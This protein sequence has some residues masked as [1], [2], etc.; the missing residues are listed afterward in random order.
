M[1]EKTIAKRY[2][3]G[4]IDAAAPKGEAEKV[5]VE[6]A[7]FA[8]AY[9][10]ISELRSAL[11]RPKLTLATKKLLVKGAFGDGLS[12][13]TLKFLEFLLEKRRMRFIREISAEY[14]RLADEANGVLRVKVSTAFPLTEDERNRLRAKLAAVTSKKIEMTETPDPRLIGGV[15]IRIGDRVIDGS[16]A[17]GLKKMNEALLERV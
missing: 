14:A 5:G 2:A 4:L 1:I 17:G 12:A 13:M 11:E 6:L 7:G 8:S 9:A 3:R 10:T 16:V 15:V